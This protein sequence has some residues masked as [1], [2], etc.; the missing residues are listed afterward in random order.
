M[1]STTSETEYKGKVETLYL[2]RDPKIFGLGYYVDENGMKWDVNA[3]RG[4]A[5][6]TYINARMVDGSH[7]YSTGT[8]TPLFESYTWKPYYYKV[9]ENKEE[10]HE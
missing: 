6:G 8:D 7:R 3:I 1:W 10:D 5:K 2:K 9:I 4:H